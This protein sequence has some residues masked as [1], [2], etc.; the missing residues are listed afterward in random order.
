[1]SGRTLHFR[2]VPFVLLAY[3]IT[4]AVTVMLLWSAVWS[5]EAVSGR[6]AWSDGLAA[7]PVMLAAGSVVGW[8]AELLFATPILLAFR[9]FR[10]PWFN[11]WSLA[12]CGLA[13]GGLGYGLFSATLGPSHWFG[14]GAVL[15][16]MSIFGVSGLAA[17]LVFRAI[18]FRATRGATLG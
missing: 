16:G 9:R 13:I 10:W 6:Y 5:Y 2:S 1:M 15:C 12:I 17:A 4:P 7:L 3:A 14:W 18:A 8:I 11:T